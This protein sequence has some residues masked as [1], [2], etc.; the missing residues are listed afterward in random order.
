MFSYYY[1]DYIINLNTFVE[2]KEFPDYFINNKGI[3]VSCK[4]KYPIIMHPKTDKDGYLEIGLR[5]KINHKNKK[6]FRRMHRLVAVTFI[7]NPNNLPIINHKNGIKNDNKIDNLEWCDNSY[8]MKHSFKVLHRKPTYYGQKPINVYYYGVL[9][10]SFRCILDCAKLLNCSST[11]IGN[12]IN[13]KNKHSKL[14]HGY[15]FELI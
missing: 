2:L 7:P 13:G 4:G 15:T 9:I 14:L 6:I 3:I 5:K 1:G 11:N 8:N 12:I 10:G